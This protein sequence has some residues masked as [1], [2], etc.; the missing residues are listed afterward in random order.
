MG[1]TLQ[2][3][4]VCFLVFFGLAQLFD[5]AQHL[6]LP[7]PFFIVGGAVLAIASNFDRRAGL[8]LNL[9]NSLTESKAESLPAQPPLSIPQPR[10]EISFTIHRPDKT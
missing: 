8:P 5:W 2:F 4:L 10:S 1:T 6:A 7:L 9:L 3:G